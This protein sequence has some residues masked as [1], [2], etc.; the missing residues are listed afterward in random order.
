M[1]HTDNQL[2]ELCRVFIER[3]G[4][5]VLQELARDAARMHEM[6]SLSR[7]ISRRNGSNVLISTA[8]LEIGFRIMKANAGSWI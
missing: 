7:S 2:L 8:K 4:E 5:L 1:A 3:H 6:M